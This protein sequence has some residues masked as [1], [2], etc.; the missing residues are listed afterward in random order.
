[1]LSHNSMIELPF[2]AVKF[3]PPAPQ[4]II[5]AVAGLT[6]A[7]PCYRYPRAVSKE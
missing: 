3:A 2:L 5:A 1:M 4:S 6:L 7:F